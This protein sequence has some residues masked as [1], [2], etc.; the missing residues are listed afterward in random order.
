MSDKRYSFMTG[1]YAHN[2]V[3]PHEFVKNLYVDKRMSC[4]A[5][6]EYLL[7]KYDIQVSAKHLSDIIKQFGVLRNY[8]ERKLNAIKQGRMIYYRKPTHEKYKSGGI[9]AKQ[10]SKVLNRDKYICQLCGNGPKTGYSLEIHH[11]NG[12]SSDLDNLQTLCYLCHRGLHYSKRDD[13]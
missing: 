13:K 3:K 8:K 10:R 1:C 7:K 5:I 6:S 2:I 12:T 9:S 11:K 4:N